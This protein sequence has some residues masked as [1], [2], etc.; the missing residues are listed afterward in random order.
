ME[1]CT[2]CK[3]MVCGWTDLI[4]SHVCNGSGHPVAL[5]TD[6]MCT[7]ALSSLIEVKTAYA[8][9]RTGIEYGAEAA[10]ARHRFCARHRLGAGLGP[11]MG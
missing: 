5:T 3:G 4:G 8:S 6:A 7:A 2:L 11:G 9:L 10:C 1:W